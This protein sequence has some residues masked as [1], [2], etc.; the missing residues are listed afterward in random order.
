MERALEAHRQR[1][2]L[3]AELL[4]LL[5][6]FMYQVNDLHRAGTLL[7]E[8]LTLACAEGNRAL[9]ARLRVRSAPA[10]LYLGNMGWAEAVCANAS[11]RRSSS[12]RR[13]IS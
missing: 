10:R 8:G 11:R 6:T 3:R 2:G 7:A 13:A 12:S 5:G 1:D 9:E 4:G